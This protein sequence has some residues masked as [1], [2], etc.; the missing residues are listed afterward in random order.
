LYSVNYEVGM[1]DLL[2]VWLEKS[3]VRDELVSCRHLLQRNFPQ[4]IKNSFLAYARKNI[5]IDSLWFYQNNFDPHDSEVKLAREKLL[6]ALQLS[7]RFSRVDVEVCIRNALKIRYEFIMRPGEAVKT[8]FYRNKEFTHKNLILRSIDNYG[9]D[10]P[11]LVYLS[12]E[13]KAYNQNSIH[14]PLLNALLQRTHKALYSNN[15]RVYIL[16]EFDLLLDF[17]NVNGSINNKTVDHYLVEEFFEARDCQDILPALEKTSLSSWSKKDILGI[18]TNLP[19][20]HDKMKGKSRC[21]Y[22]K[23]VFSDDDYFIVQK[24]KIERQPPGPYPSIFEFIKEKD[25]K[26]FAKKLFKKDEDSF[27][28]FVI[29][30]DS[31]SKWR[32]AKQV[33]DWEFEK[34]H[35]D[36][37]SKEAVRLGDV[38]FAK[39]FSNGDYI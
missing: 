38:V 35:L 5:K 6:S 29:K 23:I 28:R 34:R 7:V 8:F 18:L 30:I 9:F 37:Y 24:I 13:L 12:Q 11:F 20:I 22:P 1:R 21:L 33:I 15:R 10:I 16:N 31:L 19:K 17:Y 14:F 4:Y 26:K 32:D 39:Y 27:K 2:G 36:P 3:L 25:W